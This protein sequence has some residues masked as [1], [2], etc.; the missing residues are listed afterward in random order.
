VQKPADAAKI[1]KAVATALANSPS[2]I[3]RAA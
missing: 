3:A 2:S 1:V